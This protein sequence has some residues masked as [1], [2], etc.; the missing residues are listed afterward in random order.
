MEQKS[1]IWHL[2]NFNFFSELTMEQRNFICKNTEM[3]TIAKNHSIY[4]QESAANSVYFLKEGKVKISK[5]NKEGLEFLIAILGNGEIFG[6]S[7]VTSQTT[8]KEEAIAEENTMVCVMKEDKMKELLLLVPELNL[9]FSR[10]IEERLEKT[11]KRLEDLTFKTNP[12]RIIDFLKESVLKSEA[13]NNG[14]FVINH[15]LTHENIAK[16]TS[17]NR[18]LV[19]S[20]MSSLKKK[21]IIT[22]DRKEIR[23]LEFEKL[24][25]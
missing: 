11:Q 2:E 21:K 13:N 12:E 18:Q 15:S 25:C 24:D 14:V 16:L 19:S 9:K 5:Y 22:Y 10:I 3:R 17:T 6:E 4:F 20:V 1:K 8:R 23:I 7:A